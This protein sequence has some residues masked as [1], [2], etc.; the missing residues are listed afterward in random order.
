MRVTSTRPGRD[1]RLQLVGRRDRAVLE[2]GVD[3]LGD[4]LAH[5]RRAPPPAP[6]APSPR[7]TR[8]PRGS[9]WPRCGRRRPGTRPPRRAR[10]GWPAPRRPPLSHRCAPEL[11]YAPVPSAWLVLPTYNE[12]E[13]LEP[14]VRA[15]LPQLAERRID[16]RRSWSWT[17]PRPTAPAQIAD[18]LA[19][20]IAEVAGAAPD[21]QGRARPRLSGRLRRRAGGRRRPGPPDGLRLLARPGRRAAPD[22]G[23]GRRGRRARLA[24]RARRRGGELG[25]ARGASR[26]AAAAPTRA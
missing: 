9:P 15:V 25:A 22:R 17:T 11:G 24:L 23:R 6:G 16:A 1:A 2:Q 12:A 26:A 10:R 4:R 19:A 5:P 21:A 20:E 7:P 13:N 14:M 8:P 3:L 18:R